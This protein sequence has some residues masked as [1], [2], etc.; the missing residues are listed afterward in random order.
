M[1]AASGSPPNK[2][3]WTASLTR[4]G[5]KDDEE[6]QRPLDFRFITRLMASTARYRSLR[7][8]LV[9]L[10]ILRSLQLPGLTWI[11]TAVMTGPVATSFTG[12]IDPSLLSAA[13]AAA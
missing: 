2:P 4:L 6:H 5:E 3:N 8:W 12:E 1:N 11:L 10:V 13:G 7:N 9:V